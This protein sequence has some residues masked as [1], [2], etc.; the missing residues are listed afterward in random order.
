M[1]IFWYSSGVWPF[2]V[3]SDSCRMSVNQDGSIQLQMPE[4]EIG[5]GADTVFSQM[6]A[7]A[8]G[9]PF[10]KV[11]IVTVQDT[12]V[13]PFGM[14]AFG[15]RQTFI[16]SFTIPKVA[17]ILREK[18]LTCAAG[19]VGEE[20]S[21]IDLEDGNI[22]R[23]ADGKVLLSLGDLAMQSMYNKTLTE[24]FTA[25]A[26]AD[27][28]HNAF[29]FGC[30]FAE[31][32]VDIP[33]CRVKLVDML[34]VHDCGKLINP[35]LAEAQVHGGMSMCIGYALGE[36]LQFDPKTGRVLNNNFLDYKLSTTMD[37]PN[38]KAAFVEN[39]EPVSGFGNRALGES[40]ACS[41]APAIRNAVYHAT[42]VAM[43]RIPMTPHVLFE[44]FKENHLI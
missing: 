43:D 2:Y 21:A 27:I 3:E 19:Y 8:I 28:K 34:N 36:Q 38:L 9:V 13:T 10:E 7:D 35:A 1:A 44:K 11:H 18:I 40:P 41:G 31:V 23:M 33:L 16:T 25:E 29:N 14:G 37:H 30:T 4:T 20:V 22:V 6:A 5:Q 39:H 15:S 24:N 32:E 42:G 26:T 17:A 12:D